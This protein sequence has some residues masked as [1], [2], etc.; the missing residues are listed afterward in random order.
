MTKKSKKSKERKKKGTDQIPAYNKRTLHNHI[1]ELFKLHP[2]KHFN[3][4]QL[5]ANLNIKDAGVRKLINTVLY[6]MEDDDI[7]K[8]VSRGKYKYNPPKS[9]IKGKVQITTSGAAFI[10]TDSLDEDVYVRRENTMHALHGDIVKVSIKKSRSRRGKNPEGK[11]IEI[12]QRGKNTYVGIVRISK[13]YAFLEVTERHVPY[14]IFI[15]PKNLNGAK[16]GEK[17][18]AEITKF[19]SEKKNPEGKIIEVLGNSEDN[20]VEMHAILAEFGLPYRYP[21]EIKKEAEK[22][23]STIKPAEIKQRK[24][25]R[26]ITTFTIDPVDAK[27]FDDALSIRKLDNGFTEVGVHIA[28]VSYYVEQGSL[29]DEEAFKRA[30]SIYLPDRTVPM[31][32]ERLSN[33][34]CSLRPNEEKLTY[35]AVFELDEYG[36]IQTEWFGRTIIKSDRRFS[37]EEAQ[38]IIERGE[39]D[40]TGE[41]KELQSLAVKLRDARFNH[42]SIAFD[43]TE[44]RFDLDDKGKPIGLI[45]KESKDAHKLI[46]EFMLLANKRIANF[47]IT[48][49]SGKFEKS[50]VYRVHD[51][52][53]MEKLFNF[54]KF[55]TRFG[56]NYKFKSFGQVSKK[57]NNLLAEVKGSDLQDVIELM[58]VQSMAKAHYTTKNIGHYGLA[59]ES[60]THF[61]SPIRRY[62]D[63][64]VHRLLTKYLNSESPAD[65]NELEAMTK[66]CSEAEKTAVMAERA[67]IKYKQVEY[68]SDKLGMDFDS[69]IIGVSESGLFVRIDE[70][71]IEGMIPVREM[72]DDYYTFDEEKYCLTGRGGRNRFCIGDKINVKLV[73]ANLLKRQLDFLIN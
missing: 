53:D 64:M 68:L 35:S 65:K 39:G 3:Y 52:P 16:E 34:I 49:K 26:K 67:S 29:L 9:E 45:F 21:E 69:T 63:L 62:P 20:E 5:A 58:A 42:G 73:K 71:Q 8:I 72:N 32:P 25:F 22:I 31:L 7:I 41:I 12:V 23:S 1:L 59:F 47:A 55:I 28:D 54:S 33:N 44:V 4:K 2:D 10:I 17:A 24:D 13:T 15:L 43:R 27:D 60:Y 37:Y 66:H 30:T 38:E 36:N 19:F 6:E 48:E 11:I 56:Y 46:E 14:D 50:F 18:I 40:F 70:N 51:E 57:L 61:T